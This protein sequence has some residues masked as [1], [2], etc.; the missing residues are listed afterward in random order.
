MHQDPEILRGRLADLGA[1]ERLARTLAAI[2]RAGDVIGLRGDLGAGKTAFA[3]GF[4]AG[5]NGEATEVPSPTF[6]LVLTY[7]TPKGTV[8]HFDLYRIAAPQEVVELGFDEALDR[9]IALVEWPERAGPYWPEGALVVQLSQASAGGRDVCIFGG[10]DWPARLAKVK[11]LMQA[12][13]P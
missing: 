1:T 9:G 6:N 2:A 8:W 13:N 11:P 3:R 10:G 5:L 12:S 7:E 4:I